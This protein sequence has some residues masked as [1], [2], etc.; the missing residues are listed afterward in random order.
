VTSG[1]ARAFCCNS[2]PYTSGDAIKL[3]PDNPNYHDRRSEAYEAKGD[4]DHV[5]ADYG[6]AITFADSSGALYL[7]LR[8]AH[9]HR[10]KAPQGR[11]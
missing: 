8:E 2:S 3:N 9:Y 1:R 4:L 7:L 10:G 5:I 11:I 6:K